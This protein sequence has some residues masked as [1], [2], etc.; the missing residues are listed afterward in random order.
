[1]ARFH[2][3][4]TQIQGFLPMATDF[5][6]RFTLDHGVANLHHIDLVTDGSRSHVDGTADFSHWPEQTYHVNSTV[7]F[8]RM[9]ENLLRQRAMGRGRY[10]PIHRAVPPV[11]GRT[12]VD[13]T[14]HEPLAEVD[15][16]QLPDS[17]RCARVAAGHF[18]P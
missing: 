11:Q 10:R 18:S 5:E 15:G 4:T 1:V 3:G 17:A 7:D 2:H 13:G 9:R 12:I 8:A 14:V 16:L 6:A